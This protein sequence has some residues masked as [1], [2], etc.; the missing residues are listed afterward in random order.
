MRDQEKDI[1]C[2]S[3]QKL[4]LY[5]LIVGRRSCRWVITMVH[6]EAQELIEQYE[7]ELEIQILK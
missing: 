4:W 7:D 5:P 6:N 3:A 2:D 1:T